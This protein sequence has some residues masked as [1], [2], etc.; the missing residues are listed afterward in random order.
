[1]HLTPQRLAIYEALV[2][3]QDHPAPEAIY[4]R[5]RRR[6]PSLSL[7]TVYKTLEAL[8]RLGLATELPATGNSKRYDANMDRHHHLVC[9]RCGAVRDHH[10]PALDRLAA[11][12]DLPGFSAHHVSVLIHGLCGACA[13][14]GTSH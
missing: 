11:P 3:A 14:A 7:A 9:S 8:V 5:V 10:S 1:M 6:M 12:A 4:A 13:R 2:D